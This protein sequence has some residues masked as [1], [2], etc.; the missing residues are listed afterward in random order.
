[1]IRTTEIGIE[2]F[3]QD[4]IAD[5]NTAF[6]KRPHRQKVYLIRASE[7]ETEINCVCATKEIAERECKRLADEY[8]LSEE[9]ARCFIE[10]IEMDVIEE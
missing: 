4:F 6:I 7:W 3:E 8:G 5:M 9:E 1:M 10:C 2:R